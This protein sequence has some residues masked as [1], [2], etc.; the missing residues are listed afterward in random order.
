MCLFLV[1]TA[2]AWTSVVNRGGDHRPAD[3]SPRARHTHLKARTSESHRIRA[4]AASSHGRGGSLRDGLEMKVGPG[5]RR[6]KAIAVVR[7][8][9]GS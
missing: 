4:G 6:S 1:P 5:E 3:L 7:S 2:V 8:I 9:G